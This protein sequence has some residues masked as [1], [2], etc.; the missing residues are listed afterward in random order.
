[1]WMRVL[2][3][4]MITLVE[5]NERY[6]P[7]AKERSTTLPAI[8]SEDVA[9]KQVRARRKLDTVRVGREECAG[10]LLSRIKLIMYMLSY[11]L[12]AVA[13]QSSYRPPA[14]IF[15]YRS[16]SSTSTHQ[17]PRWKAFSA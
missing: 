3:Q 1:M 5:G 2:R 8:G 11:Q 15:E 10:M 6:G 9:V 17:R 7:Y 13:E 16:A 14:Q 4:A 12:K